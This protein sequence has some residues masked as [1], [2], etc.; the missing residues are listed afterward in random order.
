V[1]STRK[2]E[3]SRANGAKSHGPK[4]E[5]GKRAV[6][7]NGLKHGL[8]AETVVLPSESAD[9]YRAELS[10]YIRHFRP[11]GKHEMDLVLQLASIHW[12]LGRYAGVEAGLFNWRM[13]DQQERVDDDYGDDIDRHTRAAIA[14]DA[15]SGANSSLALLIRREARLHH[16]YQRTLKSIL[17][18][19]ESRHAR[20]AKVQTKPNPI[21]EQLTDPDQAP[22]DSPL[23]PN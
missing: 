20:E 5:E 8:T 9:E 13:I 14:F 18:I 11:A 10:G 2:I 7:L 15:L 3:S 22:P 12:R 4:T 23:P 6:A 1:S 16:E 19:Q 17:Q 21:S